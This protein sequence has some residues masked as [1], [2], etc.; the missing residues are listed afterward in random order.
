MPAPLQTSAV[1]NHNNG[2]ATDTLSLTG[3]TAGS[4]IIVVLPAYRYDTPSGALVSGVSSSNGGSLTLAKSRLR[5]SDNGAAQHRLGLHVYFL[6]N[7]PAGSHTITAT[8]VNATGNYADWIAVEV[9][10]LKATGA[11]DVTATTDAAFAH[12]V[13]S[14]SV[15]SGALA[16]AESFV[17][18]AAAGQGA[19]TWN[20]SSTAPMPAP[21]GFTAL[22]G[23]PY[24][25]SLDGVPFQASYA[26]VASIAPNIASWTVPND[27]YADGFI[28]MAVVFREASG[29]NYVEILT[30]GANIDGTTGWTIY[31]NVADWTATGTLKHENIAAQLTGDELRI[32]APAGTTVGQGVNVHGFNSTLSFASSVGTVRAGA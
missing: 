3:V 2:G 17:L 7:A 29:T 23:K 32:P 30:G 5:N 14:V 27:S 31:A 19:S 11:L 12:G 25:A 13:S 20:G 6:L 18:V 15:T 16:Q 1:Q 26:D 21:T 9:P 24:G 22:R 10:G 28:A 4:T 8:F